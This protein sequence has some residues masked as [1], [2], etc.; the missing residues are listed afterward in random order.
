MTDPYK[1]HAT[2]M[3]DPIIS[4]STISPDDG[5]DLP[6]TTRALYVGGAGN[7]RVTLASGDIVTFE[8]VG[9]GWHPIRIERVWSTGTTASAMV[10]CH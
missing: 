7:L 8:N 4:A 5:A 10:G 3:S 2:G 6:M 9:Q 1:N